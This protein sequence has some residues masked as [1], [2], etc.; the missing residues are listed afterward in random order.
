MFTISKSDHETESSLDSNASFG[1]SVQLSESFSISASLAACDST[2]DTKA[3]SDDS[4]EPSISK[5]ISDITSFASVKRSTVSGN[6]VPLSSSS[7]QTNYPKSKNLRVPRMSA[8]YSEGEGENGDQSIVDSDSE[9]D[10]AEDSRGFNVTIYKAISRFIKYTSYFAL[11]LWILSF[12]SFCL[13]LLKRAVRM[14]IE[15]PLHSMF[16]I[17]F[18]E[19]TEYEKKLWKTRCEEYFPPY[20]DLCREVYR[21]LFR[22]IRRVFGMNSLLIQKKKRLI[23]FNFLIEVVVFFASYTGIGHFLTI[24]GRRKWIIVVRKYGIF[25]CVC[26]GIWTD[27]FFECYGLNKFIDPSDEYYVGAVYGVGVRPNSGKENIKLTVTYLL[28]GVVS[29][30]AVLIQIYARITPLSLLAIGEFIFKSNY[31]NYNTLV[32]LKKRNAPKTIN[33]FFL[34]LKALSGNPIFVFSNELRKYL[35]NLL[36]TDALESAILLES[37][38]QKESVAKSARDRRV[39]WKVYIASMI[40]FARNSRAIQCF[41]QVFLLV[42]SIGIIYGDIRRWILAAVVVLFPYLLIQSLEVVIL[43][44]KKFRISDDDIGLRNIEKNLYNFGY[45]CCYCCAR[46]FF[47]AVWYYLKLFFY[48]CYHAGA[49]YLCRGATVSTQNTT[50]STSP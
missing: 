7:D 2:K 6:Q 27:E 29:I 11:D 5:Y 32:Q 23:F 31:V 50:L 3:S 8:S 26:I 25:L 41:Y 19:R 21:D 10:N 38:E 48:S 17:P 36:E 1:K 43:V 49:T 24:T 12:C 47:R 15:K 22:R 35:P 9:S 20:R 45:R 28:E 4:A 44:G 46:K 37:F 33:L 39:F 40:I 13:T 30:R 18:S 34:L 42:V 16:S 14:D